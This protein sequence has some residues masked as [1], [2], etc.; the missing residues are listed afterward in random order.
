M[1]FPVMGQPASAQYPFAAKAALT[2]VAQALT[3]KY[4]NLRTLFT[5]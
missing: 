1:Q 5:S 3:F 4:S 2:L